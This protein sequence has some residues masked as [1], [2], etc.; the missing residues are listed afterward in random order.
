MKT[1]LTFLVA[2]LSTAAAFG[3]GT[4]IRASS[5]FG[6]NTTLKAS[7]GTLSLQATPRLL[8]DG[9]ESTSVSYGDR[10]LV[11]SSEFDSI[12]WQTRLGYDSAGV[13]ALAYDLRL[14][15]DNSQFASLNWSNRTLL[16]ST[17]AVAANWGERY[18]LDSLSVT[19]V[20][21]QARTLGQSVGNNT[22]SWELMELYD[23]GGNVRASW[24]ANQLY[25]SNASSLSVDW[26]ERTL[27]DIAG[28]ATNLDWGTKTL[29]GGW[30]VRTNLLVDGT[31]SA[32][33]GGTNIFEVQNQDGTKILEVQTNKNVLT[34]AG[35]KIG[36]G[37]GS[38]DYLFHAAAT[39][40]GAYLEL[41][42]YRSAQSAGGL[43]FGHAGG[44]LASPTVLNYNDDCANFYF[45]PYNGEFANLQGQNAFAAQIGV[46]SADVPSPT[47][48]PGY[49][50]FG[51]T[52]TNANV[53]AARIII[54]PDGKVGVGFAFAKNY[55][56][57]SAQ[58]DVVGDIRASTTIAA[59]NGIYAI[60]NFSA[61]TVLTNNYVL[62]TRYTNDLVG[63]FGVPRRAAVTASFTLTAAVAGTATVTLYVEQGGGFTNKAT[64]SAGPLTG[65]T[66][67]EQLYL[68]VSPSAVFRFVDETSGA[69]ASVAVVSGTC[70]WFGF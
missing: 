49:M 45:I 18:M 69:G 24:T 23:S 64:I 41:D 19:S 32:T 56:N 4:A 44:T 30:T 52:P 65:L 12:N 66:T 68:N 9:V 27:Y 14:L 63:G 51:T 50:W 13:V 3:Q 48:S 60:T 61:L 37:V 55:T 25:D 28:T 10:R 26:G 70:S 53:S 39:G 11:D 33:I 35:G 21:W 59:T 5:G 29:R 16:D 42:T 8:F 54:T 43:I 47:S 36:V 2:L 57:I 31:G 15:K 20:N 67:V 6:T 38:P 46:V 17:P 40:T 22:L 62:G 58:L 34:S 7:N 1:L